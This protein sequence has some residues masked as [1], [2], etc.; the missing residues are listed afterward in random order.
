MGAWCCYAS[1]CNVSAQTTESL[2]TSAVPFLIP[3]DVQFIEERKVLQRS[4]DAAGR[5]L[6]SRAEIITLFGT[7]V[8][9]ALSRGPSNL[10]ASEAAKTLI[11][12]WANTLPTLGPKVALPPLTTLLLAFAD[13][14][15]HAKKPAYSAAE[16]EVTEFFL[17]LF[18]ALLPQLGK[19][20]YI[21]IDTFLESVARARA[22]WNAW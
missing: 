17:A 18:T 15:T 14:S 20:A 6:P 22:A 3:H 16:A 8:S 13:A 21:A 19:F 11:S 2:F 10:A 4:H 1:E 9:L 5:S 7:K 12:S